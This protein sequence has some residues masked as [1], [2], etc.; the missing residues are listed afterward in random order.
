[1]MTFLEGSGIGLEGFSGKDSL[2]LHTTCLAESREEATR[3]LFECMSDPEFPAQ[4]WEAIQRE[5]LHSIET[6]DDSP[7]AI[8]FKNL[9]QTLYGD[10]PYGHQMLGTKESVA[11]FSAAGLKR[12]YQDHRDKGQW[13]F[14]AAGPDSADEVIGSLESNFREFATHPSLAR[15]QLS[16]SR[17]TRTTK[18]ESRLTV[19]KDREQTHIALGFPGLSWGDPDRA[20]LDVLMH[21]LGGHGG[22]L[23]LELRE[24]ES[25]AYSVAPV[26]SYGCE[27]GVVGA[28][29]ATAPEK[30]AHAERRLTELLFASAK[31]R[32]D[33]TEISRAK[34]YI[35]GAHEIGLQRADSQTM[36]MALMELYGFGFDDFLSF[37]EKVK[38]VTPDD[39]KRVANRLLKHDSMAVVVVGPSLK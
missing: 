16:G 9:Q 32:W 36:T 2:G 19:H 13:V 8:A 29:I 10:A 33:G 15:R 37:P 35:V 1:M 30:A 14:A 20:A 4:Q 26:V 34:S 12:L 39:V 11:G 18:P 17:S 5:S 21:M 24:K 6:Q 22:Q 38:Q 25:L 31:N 28:Y 27:P 23:F 3:V 7:A